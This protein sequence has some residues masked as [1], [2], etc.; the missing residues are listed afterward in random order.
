MP[1]YNY[2]CKGCSHN[3]D[4]FNSIANRNT[5]EC[6]ECKSTNVTKE[7]TS[8]SVVAAGCPGNEMKHDRNFVKNAVAQTAERQGKG[9]S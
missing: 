6:P 3:F 9:W 4:Q 8:C 1:T 2:T 7:V 5:A